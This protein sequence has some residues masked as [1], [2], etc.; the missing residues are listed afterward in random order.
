M[1]LTHGVPLMTGWATKRGGVRTTWK[2]RY[3]ILKDNATLS[4]FKDS[5]DTDASKCKGIV[6]LLGS[7]VIIQG[8]PDVEPIPWPRTSAENARL[9]I[10]TP[11]RTFYIYTDSGETCQQWLSAL[12]EASG[13]HPALRSGQRAAM[14][15]SR[16][17][18]EVDAREEQRM[19][20]AQLQ[21]LVKQPGNDRCAECSKPNPTWAS[22]NLG[23]FVCISC[24]G[25]HRSLGPHGSKLKSLK[26]DD[27]NAQQI[28]NLA[29]KGNLRV[30]QRRV[31]F[32]NEHQ[33]L[34]HGCRLRSSTACNFSA[35]EEPG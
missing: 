12:R 29:R 34:T 20:K 11:S 4:Y 23:V 26:L 3:F 21:K 30:N 18:G 9:A 16:K 24:T 25:A 35:P 13:K 22:W 8:P 32:S 33:E 27:W 15:T 10:V 17:Q 7:G 2:R 31:W 28:D 14:S 5:T 19:F 1:S 6:Q